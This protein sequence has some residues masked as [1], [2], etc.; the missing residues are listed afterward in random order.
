MVLFFDDERKGK[1]MEKVNAVRS[2][3]CKVR[4]DKDSE[5]SKKVTV[6][7]TFKEVSVDQLLDA[8][9][10]SEVIRWQ[11][12]ARKK[13]D[14]VVDNSVVA[15]TFQA[16]VRQEPSAEELI[17]RLREMGYDVTPKS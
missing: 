10:K 6:R 4:A 3:V 13:Y 9:L 1:V 11:Q 12:G 14:S 7:V 8:V 5:D 2:K 15:I 16:P 17:A